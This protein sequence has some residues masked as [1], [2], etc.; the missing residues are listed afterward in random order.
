MTHIDMQTLSRRAFLAAS[1]SLVVTIA[2]PAGWSESAFAQ[3]AA[4]AKSMAPD[5]LD[6]WIAIDKQGGVTAFFGKIDGGQG[7]DT[8]VA[9]IVAEELDVP[10]ERVA[11]VLGDTRL[12]VNQGGASGS[13]GLQKG[14][15]TMRYTAAEAHRVLV[16]MASQKLGGAADQ[17]KVVDGVVSAASD[18]AKKVSYADLIGGRSFDTALE[19]NKKIGNDL[20]AKGKA[21]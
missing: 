1:G 17:L 21:K 6:S 3:A 4:G 15:L 18:P 5:Q 20:E 2:A 9:Q 10:Y 19:W 8:A 13:T 14:G 7:V 11:V 16:E 12:T